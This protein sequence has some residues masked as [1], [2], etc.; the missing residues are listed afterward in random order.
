MLNSAGIVPLNDG[1]RS[2][3]TNFQIAAIM[4]DH[5]FKAVVLAP[6]SWLPFRFMMGQPDP[7]SPSPV[8]I[9]T[10]SDR[11]GGGY[12]IPGSLGRRIDGLEEDEKAR[13]TTW[14][15]DQ[16]L[17]G[18]SSPT[19]TE[20]IVEY[21]VNRHRL[22]IHERA[23]RL[24]KF[25]S[26]QTIVA[27]DSILLFEHAEEVLRDD[28]GSPIYLETDTPTNPD[29]LAAMAWSESIT[30]DEISYLVDYLEE[31]GWVRE[32]F[33]GTRMISR[34][35]KY[36]VTVSGHVRI[37]EAPTNT[38]SSQAFVAMW[39][40]DS[41]ESAYDE[42]IAPAIWDCGFKPKR[43]DRDPTIDKIDDAIISEL[44][45]SRFLVADFT[46]GN[47]GARGGVYYE[48]GFAHGLGIPVIFTCRKDMINEIHFDTRQY[49]HIQ[50]DDTAEL[51]SSLRARILARIGKGSNV[52]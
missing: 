14:L 36:R 31:E 30:P 44:R 46:H 47:K 51:R 17:Q 10:H 19:V 9:V 22:P 1:M 34:S 3:S 28:F 4:T 50:W 33:K 16:R 42:G 6:R 43:I 5:E 23:D 15:V 38:D 8:G 39:F 48:A 40:D 41:V 35:Y 11:A 24:L 18:N 29:F 2:I 7:K 37:A 27:G 49:A 52:L 21:A 20:D 32:S 26:S 13:I 12:V 25:L 45:E